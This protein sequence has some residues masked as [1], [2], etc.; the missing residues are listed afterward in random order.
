MS[1]DYRIIKCGRF[2]GESFNVNSYGCSWLGE[3]MHELGLPVSSLPVPPGE[4]QD[5]SAPHEVTGPIASAI[6]DAIAQP[7]FRK[8]LIIAIP[9]VK[10][11]FGEPLDDARLVEQDAE[12]TMKFLSMASNPEGFAS[13]YCES[14]Y[15]QPEK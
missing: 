2:T 5:V 11:M 12:W 6:T 7:D 10:H 3:L 4:R 8:R 13:D 15:D 14:Y 1:R 9:K